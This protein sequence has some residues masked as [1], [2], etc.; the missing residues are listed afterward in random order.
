MGN[1][2][3][4]GNHA[5]IQYQL[6]GIP[7]P[8]SASGLFGGFLAPQLIENME[9]ITG[10][11]GAE[12]GDRLAAVVNM[13]GR[14]PSEQGEGELSLTY[15]SYNT[16]NPSALYG[17]KVGKLSYTVG[18]SFKESTRALDPPV[19]SPI[20][21]DVGDEERAYAR[22]VY[23]FDDRNHLTVL[24]TFAHN[25]YQI[26][27]DPTAEPSPPP[28]QTDQFGNP[29]PP[30]LP[31]DTNETENERD[32]LALTS[33]RHDFGE[34]SSLR[35]GFYF[36]HSY[37]FLFGD[38]LHALGP[39]QVPGA[40]ASDVG[41]LA[42][43][44]GGTAEYM[45]KLGSSNILRMGGQFDEL[46]G[47]T[48]YA[49]YT[50]GSSPGPDPTQTVGGSDNATSS[51]G[52]I[53]L[54][55]RASYGGFVVNAGFR[56]D[57]QNVAFRGTPDYSTQ[58]GYGPRIGVAYSFTENTVVHC[59]FGLQWMPPPVLDTAAAARILNV[60]TPG[61]T[62]LYDLKPEHDRYAEI[63]FESR[64]IPQ[65]S[66]KATAY[67][68]LSVDQLDDTGVGNTNLVSPYN[69]R[70]GRAGGIELG[71]VAVLSTKFSAFGNVV[72]SKAEGL[73]IS[74]ATYLFSSADVNN[75]S[76]QVLDHSQLWTANVGANVHDRGT[77][78]AVLVNYASG[79]RT[80]PRND[81]TV[82]GHTV[83]DLTLSHQWDFGAFRPTLALDVVNLFDA[84]Y[85]YR[86]SN[87]FNGSHYGEG[88]SIY[89]RL[90][91]AF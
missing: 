56:T 20:L 49:S 34:E 64:P 88:R 78:L 27:L 44:V 2:Y 45:L 84:H 41:R 19:L 80:G 11:L 70:E 71:T 61:Q 40:M 51:T 31:L 59:F 39:T 23:D 91:T 18:G 79:L 42:N 16:L 8:D 38:A 15:G 24:G 1:L 66:M 58:I 47:S 85:A 54:T 32:F 86:I 46:I 57:F 63:G 17:R 14:Q 36:R 90:N 81:R 28:N 6:D 37:G 62:I 82:P 67:G 72:L 53:Y 68:K 73:G 75:A 89:L 22:L 21:H 4:R 33:Y 7:L 74:S 48:S 43:H 12:Y 25:F 9:V 76:W 5:N 26:P 60:A 13:N 55:D 29:P 3:A 87:G 10:G 50:R 52:G 35:V 65:L 30:Y 83:T 77:Q 69:Y